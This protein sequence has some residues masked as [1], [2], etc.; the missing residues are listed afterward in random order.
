MTKVEE[1]VAPTAASL[2]APVMNPFVFIVGCPRSGTTLLG[3]MVDAHPSI[4]V[5]HESRW[6]PFWFLNGVGIDSNGCVTEEFLSRLTA[7]K[8]FPKLGL[9][10]RTVEA[11]ISPER[12]MSYASFTTALFDLYGRREGKPLVGDKTPRY[13]R[14]VPTLHELFP[15]ARFVHLIRDGRDTALSIMAWGNAEHTVGSFT[16]YAQDRV[17]TTALWWEWQVR[18]GCEAGASL[19]PSLYCEVRYESLVTDPKSTCRDLCA[20]LGV[21]FDPSMVRFHEGKTVDAPEL[22]AKKAW[23]PVTPGLRDWRCEMTREEL[24]SFEAGSGEL[25]EALDYERSATP[26]SAAVAQAHELRRQFALEL[27]ARRRRVPAGWQL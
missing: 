11:L 9:D 3:R 17:T 23:L 27:A 21:T 14:E 19:D 8:R 16:T 22:D 13:V 2:Q 7:Y 25:L 20:F 26:S 12:P 5:I 24:E 15:T 10:V 1:S 4:A 6:I 18:L